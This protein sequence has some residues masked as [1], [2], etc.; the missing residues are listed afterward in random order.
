MKILI[1][2]LIIL[3]V[4]LVVLLYLSLCRNT[5]AADEYGAELLEKKY[6][7]DQ[8]KQTDH[9]IS[10]EMAMYAYN[11]LRQ[12]GSDTR[13]VNCIMRHACRDHFMDCPK[14]WSDVREE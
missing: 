11:V 2:A 10:D 6:G 13:C 4:V 14:L 5:K 3:A 9:G 12:Y 8:E 7:D 1:I